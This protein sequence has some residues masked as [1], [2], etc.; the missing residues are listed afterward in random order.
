V[1]LLVFIEPCLNL[2]LLLE[3]A[4]SPP[5]KQQEQSPGSDTRVP[6]PPAYCGSSL[7]K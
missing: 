3:P 6:H 4:L 7:P 2:L 5:V 1:A